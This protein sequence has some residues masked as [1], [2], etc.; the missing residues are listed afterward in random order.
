MGDARLR[1]CDVCKDAIAEEAL[2]CPHCGAAGPG[3]QARPLDMG[4]EALL[5]TFGQLTIAAALIG[6]LIALLGGELW[7]AAVVA[8]GG[9]SQGV[10][11][12]TVAW[13]ASHVRKHL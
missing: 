8:F 3:R 9:V 11:F 7:T 10:L 6:A 5:K 2:M 13:I 12:L 1:P 4:I